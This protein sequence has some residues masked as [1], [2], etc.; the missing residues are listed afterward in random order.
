MGGSNNGNNNDNDDW[1]TD[2]NI[3][4]PQTK[5]PKAVAEIKA[6]KANIQEK[7]KTTLG[8]PADTPPPLPTQAVKNLDA[9]RDPR[10]TRKVP[11][12]PKP[13]D[14]SHIPPPPQAT[15]QLPPPPPAAQEQ[16]LP[17]GQLPP[18]FDISKFPQ[19][20]QSQVAV[21]LPPPPQAQPAAMPLV[22][23][24]KVKL[25]NLDDY[26]KTLQTQNAPELKDRLNVLINIRY[27]VQL[28]T[29]KGENVD[30]AKAITAAY[31]EAQNNQQNKE[32]F[33]RGVQGLVIEG[34]NTK[35][36]IKDIKAQQKIGAVSQVASKPMKQ[37]RSL[38]S[39]LVSFL[40]GE[41]PAAEQPTIVVKQTDAAFKKLL[42]QT[43]NAS[44]TTPTIPAP[45]QKQSFT[46][47]MGQTKALPFTQVLVDSKLSVDKL[48]GLLATYD[49]SELKNMGIASLT[50]VDASATQTGYLK[51]SFY[52]TA[53]QSDG[54]PTKEIIVKPGV[55]GVVY[56]MSNDVA[57]HEQDTMIKQICKLA[58]LNP[59]KVLSV[60]PNSAKDQ[61]VQK[62]LNE[63]TKVGEKP[64]NRP[65]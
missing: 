55:T 58:A 36:V 57:V 30:V 29:K 14:I 15:T 5:D 24:H 65:S 56:T 64:Q 41:K 46:P 10:P 44:A 27:Q 38:F 20:Q 2:P 3:S 16:K 18:P 59:E 25:G 62:A 61:R 31:L 52:S 13:M 50:T 42:P 37:E 40:K 39:R 51:I 47:N 7:L 33:K 54:A 8:A 63:V 19:Q 6:N 23:P 32:V 26:V 21:P 53:N 12:L 9:N 35:D 22:V 49:S 34:V 1:E 4:V 11:D 28:Q 43:P 60:A 17:P 45:M 48:D